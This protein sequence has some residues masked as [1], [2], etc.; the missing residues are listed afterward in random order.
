[1]RSIRNSLN[2][3]HAGRVRIAPRFVLHQYPEPAVESAF[4][5]CFSG[6]GKGEADVARII[7]LIKK[8]AM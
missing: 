3:H 2:L 5:L 1:M 7:T 4:N 6:S 8:P